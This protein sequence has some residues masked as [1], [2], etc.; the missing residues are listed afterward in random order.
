MALSRIASL[1]D[2]NKVKKKVL[3]EQKKNASKKQILLCSGAGCIASG[4]LRLKKALEQKIKEE[5]LDVEVVETGCL[6]P[7]AQGPVIVVNPDQT[8]YENLKPEDARDIVDEHL[9]KGKPVERLAPRDIKDN[10]PVLKQNDMDFFKKQIKIVLRNCGK[11]DPLKIGDY[12]AQDGYQALA[13]ALTSMTPD[14]V[15]KQVKKSGL[16]GRGGAGF[17][18]GLKWELTRVAP[19]DVK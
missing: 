13:K 9:R 17:S 3:A 11:I 7:C 10:K 14:E 1:E 4:S 18:T 2:L 5:K 15:I 16:R 12:I 8:F 6:G 19:G